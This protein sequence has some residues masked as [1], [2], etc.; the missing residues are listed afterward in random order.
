MAS[1]DKNAL[2]DHDSGKEELAKRFKQNPFVFIGTLIVLVLVIISFVLVPAIVPEAGG[3]AQKSLTFGSWNGKPITYAGGSYFAS[4][5]DYYTRLYQYYRINN[6]SRNQEYEIWQRAF[7]DTVARTAILE[8]MKRAGY[9]PPKS[10]VNKTVAQMPEFQE[11]G[12]F[13]T[14]K[15]HQFDSAARLS[16]IQETKD[17]IISKRYVDD[18]KG[19][20]SSS[21]EAD[22][23]GRIAKQQRSFKFAAIPYDSYPESEVAD[24]I[25]KNPDDFKL[26][27]LSQISIDT[28]QKDAQKVLESIRKGDTSFED[29]ARSQS[30]D[31]YAERGGDAGV[32]SAFE[33]DSMLNSK[34]DRLKLSALNAGDISEVY[35]TYSGWA[36]FRAE[37]APKDTDVSN[38][39]TIDKVRYHL[40]SDE[41]GTVEDY[42]I[43][44]A[45]E[46]A[47]R[48]EVAGFDAAAAAMDISISEFGPLPI[49]YGDSTL[50]TTLSSQGVTVLGDDAAKNE[51]FWRKAFSAKVNKASEPIVLSGSTGDFVAVIYPT[52]AVTQDES[53]IDGIKNNFTSFWLEET[54]NSSLDN[55]I[56]NSKKLENN[57]SQTYINLFFS[58]QQG[59]DQSSLILE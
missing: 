25:S 7:N 11:N 20:L 42:F 48:T 58:N 17:N 29:A 28:D 18:L 53:I 37:E 35:K 44:R 12:R 14:A 51:N 43:E 13:S 16:I 27:H 34:D 2:A 38:K 3:I 19:V 55:A 41:R 4:Q 45:Q 36:F 22:F 9:E 23:I 5:R 52:E 32:R 49:N 57:F 31:S 33:F 15:Y 10:L 30:K 26:L 59:A 54:V 6:D 47:A 40:L 21:K 8:T 56:M 1:N 24:Y 50:F 46:L 39:E